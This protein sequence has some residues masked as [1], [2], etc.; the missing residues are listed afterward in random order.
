MDEKF[1]VKALQFLKNRPRSE[2]EVRDNLVKKKTPREQ[3]DIIVGVLKQ[4]K[5]LNDHEFA[6][7]WIEQRTQFRPKGWRVIE[8]ELKQKGISDE[9]IKSFGEEKREESELD[10]AKKIVER[11]SAKYKGLTRQELY[12]KLGGYLGRRGF[13]YD[14]IKACIDDV[15]GK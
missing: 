11:H 7:W 9:I 15:M 12:V 5:F 13:G 1:Y 3:I 8:L 4:Q 6:K 14:I 10:K 2:K